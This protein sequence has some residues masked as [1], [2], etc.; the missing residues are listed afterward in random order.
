MSN[1]NNKHY[2]AY[3][4]LYNLSVEHDEKQNGGKVDSKFA[5]ELALI[6]FAHTHKDGFYKEEKQEFMDGWHEFY[7]HMFD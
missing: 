2:N 3:V 7:Y 6:Y 5:D 4:A 1:L